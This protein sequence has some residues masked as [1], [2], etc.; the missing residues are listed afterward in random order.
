MIDVPTADHPDV[1]VVMT[2]HGRSDLCARALDALV[3]NTEPVYEVVIVD[4]ASTDGTAAWLRN[5]VRGATLLF[6]DRN[7]GFGAGSNQGALHAR[8]RHLC[9]LNSDAFVR[10]GWLPP[11]LAVLD[12]EP[13]TAAVVPCYLNPDG[14][15]QEA[16]SL[17]AGDASTT[18][19]GYGDDP[20]RPEYRFRRTVDYASAACLLVRRRDFVAA[21]GFD[22]RYPLAYYEDVDLC[23]TLAT[24]GLRTVYE[25]RSQVEHVRGG[26]G[27][28]D[29]AVRL[30]T[31]NRAVFAERWSPQLQ[32]RPA[33][34]GLDRR[35]HRAAALR[36][37]PCADRILVLGDVD[38][39]LVVEVARTWPDARVT[40]VSSDQ[41][42]LA[43]GVEVVAPPDP[44]RWLESRLFHYSVVVLADDATSRRFAEILNRTQPQALWLTLP[45]EQERFRATLVDDMSL[46]GVAP[47]LTDLE[48]RTARR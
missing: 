21:G 4:S 47:P 2:V 17:V 12:G 18:S 29:E 5:E 7:V 8:G 31:S 6:N 48:R 46:L 22:P 41:T 35:P 23:F 13:D 45:L 19:L 1:T 37:A 36:D 32:W 14:T 40:A 33:L 25:P 38:P 43:A 10:P 9:F 24:M 42:L 39:A 3:R 34:A 11:L 27:T 28:I 20:R 30:I 26:S 44:D 16:A 15:L